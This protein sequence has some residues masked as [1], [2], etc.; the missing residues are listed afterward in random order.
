MT[1]D[2]LDTL[3][4]LLAKATD[5]PWEVDYEPNEDGEYGP[6]PDPGRGYE[7]FMILGNGGG[8]I[9]GTENA[10]HKL[11]EI[12]SDDDGYVTAWDEIGKANAAAIVAA[13][14]FLRDNLPAIRAQLDEAE[15]SARIAATIRI[16]TWCNLCG[17]RAPTAF[18]S[19]CVMPECP[20]RAALTQETGQ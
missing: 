11:I 19:K 15:R 20:H 10:T 4:E 9:L 1:K 3:A 18:A 17:T 13:V 5:G 16:G 14:N 12:E 7:D 6:G 8:K 2:Q